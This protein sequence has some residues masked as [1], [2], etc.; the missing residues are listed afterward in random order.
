MHRASLSDDDEDKPPAPPLRLTSASNQ[1]RTHKV[2]TRIQPLNHNSLTIPGH[3]VLLTP[4]DAAFAQGAGEL[5]L[6]VPE[7]EQKVQLEL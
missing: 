2:L 4:G 7:L 6:F 1:V 3:P 5:Q